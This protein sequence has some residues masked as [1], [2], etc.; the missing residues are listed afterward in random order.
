[1]L[2]SLWYET[3]GLVVADALAVGR[4]VVVSDRAGSREL[5]QDGVNGV[6]WRADSEDHLGEC[7]RRIA[8]GSCVRGLGERVPV[9]YTASWISP[10]QHAAQL[11]EVYQYALST[12]GRAQDSTR[13]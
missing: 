3:F 6:I 12:H 4:P 10:Q 8:Q 11:M 5:V 7:L 13:R 9:V 2:P 1:M